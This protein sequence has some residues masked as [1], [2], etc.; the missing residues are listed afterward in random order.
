MTKS[1]TL[2]LGVEPRITIPI[3]RSLHRHGIPV[4]VAS[5]SSGEPPV[6]SRC[7]RDFIR[8]PPF[9]A[10]SS[11]FAAALAKLIADR[12]YDTLIPATDTALAAVSQHD[13]RLRA[14]LRLA[15]PQPQ[16]VQRVLD[17][18]LTLRIARQCGVPVP[19]S[20]WAS[21]LAELR[22]VVGQLEFP[23]V[24]KPCRKGSKT[25]IK[26]EYFK[27]PADLEKA[28]ESDLLGSPLL[29]QEY[30]PGDGVGVEMLVHNGEAIA[31][32]QHRRLREF[33][34]T[35]GAAVIAIAEPLDPELKR[36]A[37]EL[38][39]A[40]QWEGVAM[41]EFR[42]HRPDRRIAL[43]EVNGRYWGTLSLP[44]KAGIDFPFYQWQLLHEETPAVPGSY[45]VGMRWRWSAGYIGSWHGQ[46]VSAAG[47]AISRPSL[48]KPLI[49]TFGELS[50]ATR[51]ALWQ[52]SDPIPAIAE[53]ARTIAG[54][55]AA[56]SHGLAK[57][58]RRLR[59]KDSKSKPTLLSRPG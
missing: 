14:L 56:D 38:L 20:Q 31:T 49:P 33:P 5:L 42:V 9:S 48:L 7:V 54:L 57:L 22:E 30:C 25:A 23:I 3:A 11:D 8:L 13:A 35:G 55:I 46:L 53:A 43:M 45:A 6:R 16:A 15:C 27:S 26:V 2:I 59:H 41:V 44:V 10:S 34:H 40:I 47:H 58:V 17:K 24:A 39:R 1:P 52:L 28:F 4:D 12:G 19:K 36:H 18:S 50:P 51:D 32:F 21:N 29:L 37:L